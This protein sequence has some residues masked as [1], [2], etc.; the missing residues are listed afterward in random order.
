M[1]EGDGELEKLRL[2]LAE[3]RADIKSIEHRLKDIKEKVDDIDKE[4]IETRIAVGKLEVKNAGIATILGAI[5]G[6]FSSK[7]GGH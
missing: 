3:I 1:P 4:S 2:I 6:F 7:F 5:T